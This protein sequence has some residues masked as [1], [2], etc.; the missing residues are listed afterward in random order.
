ME[1][2]LPFSGQGVFLLGEVMAWQLVPPYIE[3]EYLLQKGTSL[4][5]R[6]REALTMWGDS[7]PLSTGQ[8]PSREVTDEATYV[9]YGGYEYITEDEDI[10]DLWLDSGFDV[11]EI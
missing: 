11:V 6:M 8:H 9:F 4:R 3:V 1:S 10:R 7:A 2:P 5:A